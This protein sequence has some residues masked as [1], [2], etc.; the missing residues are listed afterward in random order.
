M[1]W[2]FQD[3]TL[4]DLVNDRDIYFTTQQKRDELLH[5]SALIAAQ[6]AQSGWLEKDIITTQAIDIAEMLIKK[7]DE[8]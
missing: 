8:R 2:F 4:E 1:K 7:V 5:V 6:L 3:T